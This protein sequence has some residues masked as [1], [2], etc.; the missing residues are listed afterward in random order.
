LRSHGCSEV[1]ARDPGSRRTQD[2]Q[3]FANAFS[4]D[5]ADYAG[6]QVLLQM[7]LAVKSA[8][9]TGWVWLRCAVNGRVHEK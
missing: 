5:T 2:P 1:F 3:A 6:T 9:D 4:N 7:K 8:L